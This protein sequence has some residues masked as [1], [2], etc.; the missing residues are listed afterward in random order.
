MVGLGETFPRRLKI[1]FGAHELGG[2]RPAMMSITQNQVASSTNNSEED[3][4]QQL[5]H[6]VTS[7][8]AHSEEQSKLSA[9]VEQCQMEAEER[10]RIVEERY[11]ETLR[12]AKEREEE[13]R[14][15]KATME[16]SARLLPT[17]SP[18]SFWAQPFNEE[19]DQTPIPQ[20]FQ[21]LVM[22]PFDGTQDP[23]THLQAFQT[24]MYISGGDDRLN[25]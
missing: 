10:H 7:L 15:V 9:K 8:Q 18:A 17:V 19:I 2:R 20:S 24:Q 23:H 22:E 21:E 6:A 12:M 13:L 14:P 1:D 16:K 11:R 5:M 25:C 4:L 3:T